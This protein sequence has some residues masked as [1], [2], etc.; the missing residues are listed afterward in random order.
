MEK[1]HEFNMPTPQTH[2]MLFK[3]AANIQKPITF[4]DL[5]TTTKFITSE[6]FGITEFAY[7]AIMPNG[8][9]FKF[10]KLINPENQIDAKAAEITGIK[11]QDVIFEK[12]FPE[13]ENRIRPMMEKSLLVGFNIKSFDI[14]GLLSQFERYK[15]PQPKDYQ[16]LD[17][18][19]IWV[20]SKITERG[21]GT[22]SEVALHFSK[23]F[24]NAHSA[25]AD[26]KACVDIMEEMIFNFGI[27]TINKF[28]QLNSLYLNIENQPKSSSS[29]KPVPI[30]KLTP[31]QLELKSIFDQITDK[32]FSVQQFA[33]KLKEAEFEFEVTKSG[34]AY[35]KNNQRIS[36]SNL[37]SE[38]VWKNILQKLTGE[39]P[40]EYI[41]GPVYGYKNNS[42][43]N[44]QHKDGDIAAK[45]IALS[46]IGNMINTNDILAFSKEQNFELSNVNFT[47]SNLI[48]TNQVNIE[49]FANSEIQAWIENNKDKLPLD[50]KL[51]PLLEA[52]KS[53]GAPPE[54]DYTQINI[55]IAKNKQLNLKEKNQLN[56]E[57]HEHPFTD[58][59]TKSLK[60]KI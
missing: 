32:T 26:T 22:L 39:I 27:T 51:K 25:F 55:Y 36:G 52:A 50:G 48:K 11:Q 14:P 23:P 34:A 33:Q 60:P 41:K 38:Y 12:K 17:L 13:F 59:E 46:K 2:P 58:N 10:C 3:F 24:L 20:D 19:D 56:N 42:N 37:G 1:S 21:K 18:R 6:N 35:T 7:I 54:I 31:A 47:L 40:S 28:L 57:N 29:S 8:E 49:L 45:I 43:S 30:D 5:E 15:L 44:E 9:T 53:I 16:S 4:F